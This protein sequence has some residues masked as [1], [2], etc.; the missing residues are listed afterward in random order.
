MHLAIFRTLYSLLF[1]VLFHKMKNMFEAELCH[2]F[3]RLASVIIRVRE[4]DDSYL[5]T[6]YP[7]N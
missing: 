7:I 1:L 3:V 4:G 5:Q 2:S 6:L